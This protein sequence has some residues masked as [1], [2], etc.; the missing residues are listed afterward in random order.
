[1]LPDALVAQRPALLLAQAFILLWRFH[2]RALPPI[3]QAVETLLSQETPALD[4]ATGQ[5]LQGG[6][7]I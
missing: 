2:L 3:L 1:M 4:Q 7:S 6:N 5:A